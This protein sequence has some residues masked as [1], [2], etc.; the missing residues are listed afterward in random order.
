MVIFVYKLLQKDIFW[1][2]SGVIL[3]SVILVYSLNP[4][5][6]K[7]FVFHDITQASR[8]TEFSLNLISGIFPPRISPNMSY[9]MGYPLFNFYSPFGYW[10]TSLIYLTGFSVVGSIKLSFGLAI[11]LS[12]I[13]MY[14]F[15]RNFF[16]FPAAF[17]GAYL[18]ILAPYMAVEV[19]VRGNVGEVWFAA[20]LP[21]ALHAMTKARHNKIIWLILTP[22]LL[23]FLFTVHNIFSLLA[24]GI[25]FLY[26]SLYKQRK[27]LFLYV[28]IG[29]LLSSY[30]LIPA[31]LELSATHA[32]SIARMTDYSNHFL[33][34][35]QLW[36]SPWGEGGSMPGCF[37][38]MSFQIGKIAIFFILL[39]LWQFFR[40]RVLR[41]QESPRHHYGFLIMLT[42]FSLS[43][44]LTLESSRFVWQ[45]LEPLLS[46][47]QFPWR[48][49]LIVLFTSS[50]IGAYGV[51]KAPKKIQFSLMVI[52]VL[53]LILVNSKYFQPK[54]IPQQQ[55]EDKFVNQIYLQADSAYAVPEYLPKSAN[56]N[57]W[58]SLSFEE[59]VNT[60][61]KF[62][63]TPFIESPQNLS[64][65]V[66]KNEPFIKQFRIIV[67]E[68]SKGAR[69]T[70][71][72]HQQPNWGINA[73]KAF[74]LLK[75]S[76]PLGR[77]VVQLSQAGDYI[78]SIV[79]QQTTIQKIGNLLTIATFSLYIFW[80]WR[81][82]FQFD[83]RY[84]SQK[85]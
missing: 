1:V 3:L 82:Y 13:G 36:S 27:T 71:K 80:V 31:I 16:K 81:K 59:N 76:D 11:V 68:S 32:S 51:D 42:I 40:L 2:M 69:I 73:N 9:G 85:K 8:V 15:L 43:V 77:P 67:P 4:L 66:L 62:L 75:Q 46:L 41:T 35:I 72:I 83:K 28:I 65:Q 24:V 23:S 20:L 7:M 39:G 12:W 37:D 78:I 49:L 18:Y 45:F 63:K 38:G 70:L 5:S 29:L 54:Q 30:F 61:S 14:F 22:L 48:F 10:V 26:A 53:G 50:F 79:Y 58:K 21:W 19:Y 55:Y 47:F 57:Y 74:R 6:G 84:E 17:T 52:G 25:T 33:C 64:I 56:F 60:Q 44:F 34:P